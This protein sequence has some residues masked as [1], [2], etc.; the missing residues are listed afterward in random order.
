MST[1]KSILEKITDTVKEVANRASDA[2]VEA[3]KPEPHPAKKGG[4]IEKDVS[5]TTAG[6]VPLAADGIVADPLL[7]Q[8]L[9][10]APARPKRGGK[11]AGRTASKKATKSS[12][13]RAP[14]KAGKKSMARK[15]K[16]TVKT[17]QASAAKRAAGK[18]SRRGAKKRSR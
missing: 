15:S 7:V 14:K 12:A 13:R 5:E 17:R 8:P 3:L 16:A 4:R 10:E 18:T 11:A 2:A 6:Y 9:A 1:D